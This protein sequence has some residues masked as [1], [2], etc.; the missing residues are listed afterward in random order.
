[1]RC[2]ISDTGVYLA[3][4]DELE[5]EALKALYQRA[6]PGS[7]RIPLTRSSVAGRAIESDFSCRAWCHE[8][9]SKERFELFISL[10]ENMAV[11]G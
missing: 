1:M 9:K 7:R 11:P 4:E 3:P 5:A 10:G 6:S 2:E 8:L